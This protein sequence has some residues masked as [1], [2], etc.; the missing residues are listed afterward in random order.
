MTATRPS[1]SSSGSSVPATDASIKSQQSPGKTTKKGPTIGLIV[2][3]VV[4]VAMLAAPLGVTWPQQVVAAVGVGVVVLWFTEAL[5][6]AISGLL[7]VALLILLGAGSANEIVA[8]MGS[9]TLLTFMGAFMIAQAMLIHGAGRRFALFLLSFD[10][11]C[12]RP[13]RMIAAFGG[14]SAILSTV[15]S[16]TA[17]VAM[18]LPTAMGIIAVLT[19]ALEEGDHRAKRSNV[20]QLSAGLLLAL[21]YGSSVGGMLTPIG[22][23]PNLIGIEFV[24]EA[25]GISIGFFD[26]MLMMLPIGVV[27]FIAMVIIIP[28]FNPSGPLNT[29]A[30]T[31][32]IKSEQ[33]SLGAISFAERATIAVLILTAIAWM[34][35]SFVRIAFGADADISIW[36]AERFNEGIIAITGAAL[37]FIIPARSA[38]HPR[39]LTWKTGKNIDWGT[40]MLF[41]SGIILG[42]ALQS[43]GLAEV[44][45]GG[46]AGM[47]GGAGTFAILIVAV[48]MAL[49]FS[50][51]ASNTAST[52]VIVPIVLPIALA[53]GAD[54]ITI[55]LA[56]TLAATLGFMLP[57]STT[58]NAIVYGSGKLP[59]QKMIRTGI[60]FDI[61][62]IVVIMLI[63]PVMSSLLF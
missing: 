37:L 32:V 41:A 36:F 58:Q 56:A 25:T 9:T 21:T 43:T 31:D 55:G 14:T 42:A 20:L 57:V 16:N 54:P 50:E 53:S 22:S 61:V 23:P 38:E 59:L 2:A 34:A 18:L 28:V 4:T 35:P 7:G 52:L 33:R 5:P 6:L 29:A 13:W 15:I 19:R 27:L 10:W 1:T 48:V 12:K 24:E 51:L 40:I 45:G 30:L 62:S 60:A 63:M 8:P 3:A 11:V 46:V 17:T 47:L 39:L 44:I 49:A 26:W